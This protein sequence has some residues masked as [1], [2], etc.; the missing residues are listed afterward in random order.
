MQSPSKSRY[1]LYHLTIIQSFEI[2]ESNAIGHYL[3]TRKI[4]LD[5]R[6][7]LLDWWMKSRRDLNVLNNLIGMFEKGTSDKKGTGEAEKQMF[8]CLTD[9]YVDWFLSFL[10]YTALCE[11]I[12]KSYFEALCLYQEL[13]WL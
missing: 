2:Y 11:H 4:K 8:I 9:M 12:K 13:L 3:E 1:K 6:E 10:I 7:S 5:R